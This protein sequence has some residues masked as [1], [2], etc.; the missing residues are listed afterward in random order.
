MSEIIDMHTH[1]W[2][3]KIA[4]IAIGGRRHGLDS[5][6]DGTVSGLLEEMER[7]A[8]DRSVIFGRWP[9][10]QTPDVFGSW[11]EFETLVSDL[12]HS[13]SIDDARSLYWT[14]RPS[15]RF[16]TLEFR[17]SD[18]C[19]TL[20]EAVLATGLTRALAR[21]A[22]MEAEA[23]VEWL[24]RATRDEALTLLVD[25]LRATG[26]FAGLCRRAAEKAAWLEQAGLGL[27]SLEE[28]G[29]NERDL[30][31][32]HFGRLGEAVP[33]DLS[34]YAQATGF[35]EVEAFRRAVARDYLFA[36]REPRDA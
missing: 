31:A 32:W 17:V 14:V 2:P 19:T 24:T 30:F 16:P 11:A 20:D 23:R 12:T 22:L 27:V 8:I 36:T 25:E 18:A 3:D 15:S 21:T 7:S 13:G 1:V 34:A 9:T 4:K 28:L 33:T 29:I 26:A 5:F 6:G 35:D 10:F